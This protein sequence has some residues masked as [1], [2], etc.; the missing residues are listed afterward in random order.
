[1]EV[2]VDRARGVDAR[3]AQAGAELVHGAVGLDAQGVLGHARAVAE[4]RLAAVAG[5]RVDAIQ[6]DHQAPPRLRHQT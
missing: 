5:A 4:R 6:D 3:E 1:V 2:G